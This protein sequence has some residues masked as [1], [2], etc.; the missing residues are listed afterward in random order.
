MNFSCLGV[1]MSAGS[2]FNKWALFRSSTLYAKKLCL[3]SYVSQ[4]SVIYAFDAVPPRDISWK[5][6]FDVRH[7]FPGLT[8]K[9]RRSLSLLLNNVLFYLPPS[10][11]VFV[12]RSAVRVI[13]FPPPSRASDPPFEPHGLIGKYRTASDTFFSPSRITYTWPLVLLITEGFPGPRAFSLIDVFLFSLAALQ[14][15]PLMMFH[16]RQ[17]V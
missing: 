4:T 6:A 13:F 3:L 1:S 5:L 12:L 16:V 17:S 14:N 2:S 15:T 11:V 9:N 10:P 8:Y 7:F